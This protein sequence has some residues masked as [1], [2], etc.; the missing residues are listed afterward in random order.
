[1]HC[2][3]NENYYYGDDEYLKTELRAVFE[4]GITLQYK[5]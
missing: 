3:I 5:Y 2:K 1:M 4:H